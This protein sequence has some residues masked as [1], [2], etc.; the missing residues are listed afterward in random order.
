[1]FCTHCGKELFENARFCQACGAPVVGTQPPSRVADPL[2]VK[3]VEAV[4]P[5]EQALFEEERAY[6]QQ[7][8]RTMNAECVAWKTVGIILAVLSAFLLIVAATTFGISGG[9]ET[10]RAQWQFGCAATAFVWAFVN[11]RMARKA[12]RLCATVY[13][14]IRPVIDR[15]SGATPVVVALLFNIVAMAFVLDTCGKMKS[16]T[17][18]L[19]R[20][21]QRQQLPQEI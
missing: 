20:I 13:T 5:D 3:R 11:L 12:R 6:V 21:V 14:D 16:K 8:S 1:M 7:C 9:E 2:P 17:A 18:V 10:V 4:V 19:Q 15:Y